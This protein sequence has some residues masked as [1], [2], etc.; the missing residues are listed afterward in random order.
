VEEKDD[1]VYALRKN[2]QEQ[3]YVPFTKSR[4]AQLNSHVSMHLNKIDSDNYELASAW[5]G[6]M[7]SPPFPE[8]PNATADSSEYWSK[9][10]F[11]WGS[12]EIISGSEQIVCPWK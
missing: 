1:I 2:R 4:K 8:D 5:I 11:V 6:E 9:H 12:Q 3:G 10:A 7:D